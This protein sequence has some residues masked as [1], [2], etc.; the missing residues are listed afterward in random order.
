MIMKLLLRAVL[1]CCCI[2][3][4]FAVADAF[5]AGLSAMERGHYSTAMR[6]WLKLGKAGAAEA[7]NNVGHLYEEGYGVSQNYAEAMVWYR[8]AAD[9]GLAEAQH[10]VGMLYYHG[11]GVAK[12]F[13][14]S[15]KWFKRASQQDLADSQYM[16]GLSYHQGKGV[17]LDYEFAK[18]WFYKSA[19]Q[20]YANAQFM[21][22]YMLQAGDGGESEPLKALVWSELAERN[23][24]TDASDISNLSRLLVEDAEQ[25]RVPALASQCLES[26]YEQCP[27]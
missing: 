11:Y 5:Q 10:N 8:Q 17:G 18:Y 24:K 20:S 13:R 15:L 27:K 9:Q 21:Y 14:E 2:I 1:F 16:L 26:N 19:V 7:Q 12:N 22:A 23:G 25:A 4:P 6:A 3:P